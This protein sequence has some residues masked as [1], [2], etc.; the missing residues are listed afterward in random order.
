[1]IN[2]PDQ[3]DAY[4]A[5][6]DQY[7]QH[8]PRSSRRTKTVLAGAFS[9]AYAEADALRYALFLSATQP[10]RYVVMNR[11]GDIVLTVVDGGIRVNGSFAR[12]PLFERP[13]G[14]A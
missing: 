9:G 1:M 8:G 7:V 10:A 13:K 12:L 5:A 3:F 4:V 14:I 11:M 6:L 2:L